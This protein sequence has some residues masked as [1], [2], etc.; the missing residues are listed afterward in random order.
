MQQVSNREARRIA[1]N[2]QGF[3]SFDRQKS[4]STAQFR[5]MMRRLHLLQLD[6]VPVVAR[7]QYLPA[8]SRLGPYRQAMLDELAYTRDEWFEAWAHEASMLPVDYQPLLRWS[9]ARVKAGQVWRPLWGVATDSAGM[10]DRVLR[11]IRDNGP[12][13]ASELPDPGPRHA[14]PGWAN[15]T[16]GSLALDYL[17]RAGRLGVRRVGNFEKQFDLIENIVPSGILNESDPGEAHALREL[18]LLAATAHGIGTAD[19]LIDYFRLPIKPSRVALQELVEDGRLDAVTVENW[20]SPAYTVAGKRRTRSSASSAARPVRALVSPFDPLVWYRKRALRLFG[21]D[22]RLE[23]YTPQKK[24]RWGYYVLPFLLGDSLAA[25]CDLKFDRSSQVLR[26]PAAHIE[27]DQCADV[28]APALAD[29]LVMMAN[30]LGADRVVV[31]RRG[32]LI[33]ALREALRQPGTVSRV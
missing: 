7:T 18:L 6:A 21:F 23:I 32:K 25:R 10:L 4:V 8:Y 11:Q 33:P 16:V 27:P 31:G 13:R 17:F 19:D 14:I 2:A 30:W 15:R 5:T 26:V 20:K 9:H 22:Y 1:L 29:E 28:V 12:L 24:R 3:G